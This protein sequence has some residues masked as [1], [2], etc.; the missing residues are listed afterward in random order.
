VSC[1]GLPGAGDTLL[2]GRR[3]DFQPDVRWYQGF[4]AVRSLQGP[5]LGRQ[6]PVRRSAEV[7]D[8]SLPACPRP[9]GWMRLCAQAHVFRRMAV[10]ETGGL[11]LG[12]IA[13]PRPPG[14]PA[15]AKGR[16]VPAS[17]IDTCQRPGT[18]PV[19]PCLTGVNSGIRRWRRSRGSHRKASHRRLAR[20]RRRCRGPGSSAATALP[21][22]RHLQRMEAVVA[23]S[24]GLAALP[25]LHLRPDNAHEG[26]HGALEATARDGAET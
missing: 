22:R 15:P 23:A 10:F 17:F 7:A 11:P 6:D 13:G 14:L 8:G 1:R 20:W 2:R 19:I 4:S 12:Q 24:V 9:A 16:T 26:P 18:G 3:Q 5:C 25:G 21:P